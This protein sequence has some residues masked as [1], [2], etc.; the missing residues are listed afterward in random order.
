MHQ[1][2]H[3]SGGSHT[4]PRFSP[5]HTYAEDVDAIP[6]EQCDDMEDRSAADS[7][8][9]KDP[10]DHG[11][12][13]MY[14]EKGRR[15]HGRSSWGSAGLGVGAGFGSSRG[16]ASALTTGDGGGDGGD[17]QGSGSGDKSSEHSKVGPKVQSWPL[18]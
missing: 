5:S 8:G 1:S 2:R 13:S 9:L 10:L 3:A 17:G 4:S 11:R 15:L 7:S 12:H 16:S 6:E 14:S 18:S